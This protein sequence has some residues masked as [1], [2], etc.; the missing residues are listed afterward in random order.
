MHF[1]NLSWNTYWNHSF[2]CLCPEHFGCVTGSKR[3]SPVLSKQSLPSIETWSVSKKEGPHA[4]IPC[5]MLWATECFHHPSQLGLTLLWRWKGEGAGRNQCQLAVAVMIQ[6]WADGLR[7]FRKQSERVSKWL[8]IVEMLNHGLKQWLST[9]WEG[10]ANPGELR[11]IQC[12]AM[13][14]SDEGVEPGSTP[15]QTSF[16][17]WHGGGEEV[18]LEIPSCLRSS[19]GKQFFFL[20]FCVCSC[21]TGLVLICYSLG[22]CCSAVIAVPSMML[23]HYADIHWHFF[24]N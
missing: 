5:E 6:N 8:N 15:S 19:K 23:W 3:S 9:W 11:C 18:L 10:R 2:F 4:D 17:G 20:C 22:L 13:Q 24:L 12:N 14:L 7:T 16:K 1:Q 21:C